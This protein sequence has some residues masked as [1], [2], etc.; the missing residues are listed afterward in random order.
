MNMNQTSD[1]VNHSQDEIKIGHG[2]IA[3]RASMLWEMAGHPIDRDAEFWLQAEAELLGASQRVRL[4]ELNARTPTRSVKQPAPSPQMF[5][6]KKLAQK[7]A[8]MQEQTLRR[9]SK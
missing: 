8:P 3:Q 1:K 5:Q 7:A 9:L 2:E 6:N 4:P